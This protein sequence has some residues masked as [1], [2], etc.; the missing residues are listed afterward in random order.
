M[1]KR[2]GADSPPPRFVA[3]GEPVNAP[4][5]KERGDD[6]KKIK[7]RK[8]GGAKGKGKTRKRALARLRARVL[9]CV[10]RQHLCKRRAL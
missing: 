6:K 7:K 8:R 9:A 2:G 10:R 5:M 1:M 3:N 4:T